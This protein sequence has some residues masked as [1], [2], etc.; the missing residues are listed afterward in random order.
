MDAVVSA[1]LDVDLLRAGDVLRDPHSGE[2]YA[3]TN[4]VQYEK[5][6][7]GVSARIPCVIFAPGDEP[8]AHAVPAWIVQNRK[9]QLVA[10]A[11]AWSTWPWFADTERAG[12]QR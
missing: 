8:L 5:H 11:D 7:I 6:H 12:G 4:G 1:P 2:L 10:V 3:L 9:M